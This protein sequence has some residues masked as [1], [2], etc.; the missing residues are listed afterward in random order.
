MFDSQ[1]S[2]G[3]QSHRHQSS[4][5][6]EVGTSLAYHTLQLHISLD[7]LQSESFPRWG[8]QNLFPSSSPNG[9]WDPLCPRSLVE[10]AGY[11]DSGTEKVMIICIFFASLSLPGTS[12][13]DETQRYI[14]G[15][16]SSGGTAGSMI[17]SSSSS[18]S[19]SS[20]SS[21][22]FNLGFGVGA[23]DGR[24]GESVVFVRLFFGLL[25][26]LRSRLMVS[27]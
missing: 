15:L 18:T 14:V 16:I 26:F 9:G 19:P 24:R 5:P 7:L 10:S 21:P 3:D 8:L 11:V 22:V 1:L 4:S 2:A 12:R 17:S 20:A 25:C 13:N 23:P 6:S 27:A